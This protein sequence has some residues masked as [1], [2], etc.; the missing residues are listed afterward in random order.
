MNGLM[1][2]VI[3]DAADAV[4]MNPIRHGVGFV[5][6]WIMETAVENCSGLGSK[7]TETINGGGVIGEAIGGEGYFQNLM[8]EGINVIKPVAYALCMLFFLVALLELAMSERMTMEY[9][10][11]FF[12]KLVI[13]VAAV[14]YSGLFA[15]KAWEFGT[16]LTTQMQNFGIGENAGLV[17]VGFQDLFIQYLDAVGGSQWL[18][19]LAITLGIGVP[20]TIATLVITVVVYIICL[21]RLLEMMVRGI[22]MPIACA[23]LS[24]D[25][26]RGSG[27]RY[28]RK[29]IGIC[30]QGAV[31]VV[32]GNITTNIMSK[33]VSNLKGTMTTAIQVQ[34]G[35]AN[36]GSGEA[37]FSFF[38][39]IVSSTLAIV[40]VAV[41]CVS[42]MFKSIGIVND[43]F[44]G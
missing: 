10:A 6:G 31:L 20:I 40:G 9:M 37:D 2:N 30:A 44:G 24:D 18:A 14:Y 17:T 12:S 22:F 42:L 19:L 13:G 5:C 28:I 25:G 29:F 39:K 7:I 36:S 38:G 35:K 32:L 26:W 43:A 4:I 34:I 21:T 1:L 16:A 11:K 27:G 23:M 3:A 33:I 41:A 15:M 8:L